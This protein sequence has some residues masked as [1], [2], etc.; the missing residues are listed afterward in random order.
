MVCT[1]TMEPLLAKI[2][3]RD[4]DKVVSTFW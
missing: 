1:Q 2:I 4:R 3:G